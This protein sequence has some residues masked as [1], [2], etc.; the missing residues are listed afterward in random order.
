MII[1]ILC[2]C[3]VS[4]TVVFIT[5]T[6]VKD[7]NMSIKF[8]YEY[9]H[10][11]T[12]ALV[13][14]SYSNAK[15]S[16]NASNQIKSKIF[17]VSKEFPVNSMSDINSVV[18]AVISIERHLFKYM[19]PDPFNQANAITNNSIKL[20]TQPTPFCYWSIFFSLSLQTFS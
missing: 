9:D 13:K 11:H 3:A 12:T 20:E 17:S 2:S 19:Y 6:G 1:M 10:R 15:H 14:L 18:S 5:V 7:V 4:F 8:R 16:L